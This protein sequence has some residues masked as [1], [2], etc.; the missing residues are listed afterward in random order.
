[1]FWGVIGVVLGVVRDCLR[2]FGDR[3]ATD[4]RQTCD[5]L[6]RTPRYATDMRQTCDRHATDMRQTCDRLPRT[7]QTCDRHATELFI[8]CVGLCARKWRGC[9]EQG[10]TLPS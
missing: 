8:V 2:V 9:A 5:R 1:M 3:H 7:P 4:M 6:P 10:G